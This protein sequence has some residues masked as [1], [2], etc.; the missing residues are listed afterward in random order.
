MVKQIIYFGKLAYQ[1]NQSM[2]N[3][4]KTLLLTTAFSCFALFSQAQ[5]FG[6]KAGGT[7]G[8]MT[9]TPS[10]HFDYTALV[11]GLILDF[12]A[13]RH[14]SLTLSFATEIQYIEKPSLFLFL[15]EKYT[16]L[17]IPLLARLS[18]SD[19]N[20]F[21]YF[22]AGIS[23]DYGMRFKLIQLDKEQSFSFSAFRFNPID[24][25]LQLGGGFG[26]SFGPG[27]VIVD[28]RKGISLIGIQQFGGVQAGGSPLGIS[29]YSGTSN[30][31]K[32]HLCAITIGYSLPLKVL[33]KKK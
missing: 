6:L 19:K 1:N 22:N 5:T 23:V 32:A 3:K 14:N 13:F 25:T 27:N 18:L 2:T 12:P 30:G 4:R 26:L 15:I 8:R 24:L 33:L 16:Y 28:F 17:Q 31:Y 9:N 29:L 20:K 11:G 21:V 10:K 7:I